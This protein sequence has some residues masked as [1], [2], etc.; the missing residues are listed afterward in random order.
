[1]Q[2]PCDND[3]NGLSKFCE[4]K[5]EI[6]MVNNST[7]INETVNHISP[8]VFLYIP[9]II[10]HLYLSIQLSVIFS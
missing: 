2:L 1:M 3:R 5:V 6:V 4:K 8:C 7:N 10:S 9:G